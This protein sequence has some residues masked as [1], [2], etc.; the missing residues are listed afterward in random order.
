M[1]HAKNASQRI[2]FLFLEIEGFR[3][4]N[5]FVRQRTKLFKNE[6]LT[7]IKNLMDH[8]LKSLEFDRK[9]AFIKNN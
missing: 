3:D 4:S 2:Y 9:R 8:A 7:P 5:N 1:C 6:S